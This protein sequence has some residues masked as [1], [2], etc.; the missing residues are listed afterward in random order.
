VFGLVSITSKHGRT[1][2][3]LKARDALLEKKNPKT[4]A[5]E[6]PEETK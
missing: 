5:K 6:K 2:K 1:K 4:K 3:K